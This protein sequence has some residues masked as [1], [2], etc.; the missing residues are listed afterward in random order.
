MFVFNSFEN[1]L[2]GSIVIIATI[3][4]LKSHSL[5]LVLVGHFR[6]RRVF[7]KYTN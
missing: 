7:S 4:S 6:Y 1:I 3:H 2:I 5:T